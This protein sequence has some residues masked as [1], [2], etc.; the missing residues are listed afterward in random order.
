MFGGVFEMLMVEPIVIEL[1]IVQT[2]TFHEKS[3]TYNCIGHHF[4][5]LAE[6]WMEARRGSMIPWITL[7]HQLPTNGVLLHVSG[8]N[9]S[10]MFGSSGFA[11]YLGKDPGSGITYDD[12]AT[13]TS[14][15]DWAILP[16]LWANNTVGWAGSVSSNKIYKW[17]GSPLSLHMREGSSGK[18][19]LDQNYPNPAGGNTLISFT[20]EYSSPVNL[21]V[22]NSAGILV[23]Q[24]MNKRK[25][26]GTHVVTFDASNLVSGVYYYNLLSNEGIQTR[27]MQILKQ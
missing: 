13:W 20:L 8:T 4:R 10:Y 9:H 19:I 14:Q 23:S 6:Q 27:K 17:D 2:T 25:G 11:T 7:D 12:G 1:V 16:A 18:M 24:L 15:N 26:S 3:W 22:Y 21:S 5:D